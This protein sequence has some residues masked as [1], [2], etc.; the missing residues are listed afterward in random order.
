MLPVLPPDMGESAPDV[1]RHPLRRDGLHGTV[2][3]GIPRG[4]DPAGRIE[5][6]DPAA[7]LPGNGGE[8]ASDVYR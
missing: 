2:R 5:R 3:A 6:R 1:D 4:R 7:G 8:V